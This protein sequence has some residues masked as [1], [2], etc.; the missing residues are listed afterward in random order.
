MSNI[1]FAQIL[2]EHVNG[3]HDEVDNNSFPPYFDEHRIFLGW[4]AYP[5]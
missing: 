2:R 1:N 3:D 4:A 5:F